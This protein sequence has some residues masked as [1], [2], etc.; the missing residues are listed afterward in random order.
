MVTAAP[1][2]TAAWLSGVS[3]QFWSQ[4]IIAEVYT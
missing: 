3:E 1:A 4:A 2:L